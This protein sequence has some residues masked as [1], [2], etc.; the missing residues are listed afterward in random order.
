[1]RR[2]ITGVGRDCAVAG[3]IQQILVQRFPV[4]GVLITKQQENLKT[5]YYEN[6]N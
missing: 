1:V 5:R 2:N 6:S 4:D 3:I